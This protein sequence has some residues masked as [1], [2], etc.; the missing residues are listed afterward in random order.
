MMR[1]QLLSLFIAS[2]ATIAGHVT[3]DHTSSSNQ[4]RRALGY[5]GKQKPLAG[6][7][8]AGE[9]I[10]Y[11]DKTRFSNQYS[12]GLRFEKEDQ[13]ISTASIKAYHR[14]KTRFSAQNLRKLERRG[15]HIGSSRIPQANP[16]LPR[17]GKNFN[18]S[19]A[20]KK[21]KTLRHPQNL[22]DS[23]NKIRHSQELLGQH[24]SKS[25]Q[26]RINQCFGRAMCDDFN[27][28]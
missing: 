5:I 28:V 24:L 17:L 10:P 11:K 6:V 25:L 23:R 20:G 2:I 1:H 27:R 14:E 3:S 22:P 26:Q 4:V 7:R 13:R 9:E 16:A 19:N 8:Y 12:K 21:T 18:P 15:L